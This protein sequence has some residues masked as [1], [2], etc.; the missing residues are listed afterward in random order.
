MRLSGHS[1]APLWAVAAVG[2]VLGLMAITV[3]LTARPSLERYPRLTTLED[4][5]RGALAL[6][7]TGTTGL[8]LSNGQDTLVVD[9]FVTRPSLQQIMLGNIRPDIERVREVRLRTGVERLTAIMVGHSHYDHSMDAPEWIKQAGGEL[10]GTASTLN[11][12]EA[13][14]VM[15][16]RLL[17]PNNTLYRGDFTVRV[18]EVE[19]SPGEKMTGEI[20]STFKVP[21]RVSQYRT[22]QGLGFQFQHADCR[23]VVIPSAG[24]VKT[25]LRE[26]PSDVIVL[27]IGQLGLQSADYIRNFWKETVVASGARLVI[28][29]H[30][31]DFSRSLDQPL[32]PLP[33]G[34]ERVDVA[35]RE[36][37]ALAG[38]DITVAMP[39]LYDRLDL[40]ASGRC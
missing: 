4:H 34:V 25:D 8:V 20:P 23:I 7:F 32:R 39:V 30:W 22:G 28:P 15:S 9:G 6:R 10:W 16:G 37:M 33:Y 27:S 29:V 24:K 36:I 21:A 3:A 17:K 1:L 12:G 26:Y 31:D 14:G 11:I 2:L 19:H 13:E 38:D 18:F 5:E 40:G 35:M